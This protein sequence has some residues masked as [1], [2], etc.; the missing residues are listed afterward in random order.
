MTSPNQPDYTSMPDQHLDPL[1]AAVYDQ[2]HAD[3]FAANDVDP[4]VQVLLDLAD[5][6]PIVEFAV[7]TG[8]IAL[9]LTARGAE[10]YGI[11]FSDA[12][13]A[14]LRAKP[15]AARI[16]IAAGD[17]TTTRVCDEAALVY[18]VFNTIGNLRTQRG[19]VDCFKNAAAHL[20]PG[21]RFVIELVTPQIHKL[22]AGESIRPFDV[23]EH[24]LGFDEYIDPVNQLLVSHHYY[25]DGDKARTLSGAFRYAWPSE[26]DLM[27]QLAG[28]Q[29]EH[30][31]ADWRRSEFTAESPSHVSVWRKD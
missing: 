16:K 13:L 15:G 7:G 21:G 22:P 23:S 12:M 2:G 17:M 27:A 29:L 6:G 26:L 19:Q 24:H 20:A 14:E 28:M 9:P 25:I 30:R 18:L 3:R 8:R 1:V 10:V 4:T 11:D 5:D 31:W